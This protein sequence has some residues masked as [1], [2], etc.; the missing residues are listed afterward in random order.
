MNKLSRRSLFKGAAA[1]AGTAALSRVTPAFAQSAEKSALLVVFLESGYNA[2]FGS[3]DSFVSAGTF[4]CTADNVRDL[5][6]GL[7][8][9]KLT[10]GTGLSNLPTIGDFAMTHMASVGIAH[11]QTAHES[12]QASTWSM[13]TRNY[14]LVLA[15][16]MGGDAAIKAAIVGGGA[17]PSMDATEGDVSLQGITDM[18]ATLVALGAEIDASVPKRTISTQAMAAAQAMSKKKLLRSPGTLRSMTDGLNTGVET[19]KK[20]SLTIDYPGLCSAYGVMTGTTGVTDFNTQMMAAEVMIRSGSNLVIATNDGWDSHGDT[21][22]M[23]VR[24]KMN[25]E[26]LPGLAIFCDRMLQETGRNVT[27]AIWGD[28]ARS[29][30]GS[31]HQGNLTATVIGKNVITGTTGHCDE[32]VGLPQGG[33]AGDAFWGYLS[34]VTRCPTN[35]FGDYSAHKQLVLT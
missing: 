3:A 20:G 30:P 12:A 2:L 1:L 10:L 32:N 28:F 15:K 4:G 9:D 23:T 27:V 16:A 25:A 29:L 13:G 11:G 19:L 6:K 8:I 31:D 35:P 26:I 34:A 22:G 5:G 17:V 14:G 21:N 33:P 24:G 18:K 7:V